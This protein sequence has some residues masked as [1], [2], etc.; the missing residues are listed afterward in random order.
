MFWRLMTAPHFWVSAF[1]KAA[2]CSGVPPACLSDCSMR[3][4]WNSGD[5]SAALTAPLSLL[6]TSAGTPAGASR[7]TQELARARVGVAHRGQIGQRGDAFARGHGQRA[8]LA[9]SDI[10]ACLRKTIKKSGHFPS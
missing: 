9:G 5:F 1:M 7:P 2:N 10:D 8:H 4:F 6:T 3:N